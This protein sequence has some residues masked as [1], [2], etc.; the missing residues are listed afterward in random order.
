MIR[1]EGVQVQGGLSIGPIHFLHRLG[2]ASSARSLLSPSEELLRFEAARDRAAVELRRLSARIAAHLGD[3][4]AAIF[5]FQSMMLEDED[6]LR[7]IYDCI[8][9]SS[10]AESAIE[11]A[12]REAIRFFASLDSSYLR[13]RAA[14][15]RDVTRRLTGILSQQADPGKLRQ[16]PA[17]LVAED[18]TPSETALLDSG[19]LLGLVSR[20]GS[21]DSHVAILAKAI[22]VPTLTGVAVDPH[23]EG[24][25]AILDGDHGALIVDPDEETMQA[26]RPHLPADYRPI[27]PEM[28][29]PHRVRSDR[30][31]RLSAMID[32]AWEAADAYA[33]GAGAISPYGTSVLHGSR[34]A[35]P[36]EEEQFVEYRRTVE[37]MH[38][39]PVL[40]RSLDVGVLGRG[41]ALGAFAPAGDLAPLKAQ[42]R[43]VLRAADG[44]SGGLLL[45]GV[46]SKADIHRARQL[47]RQ[48]QR[49][50]DAEGKTY[51][52]V[53]VGTEIDSP[54]SVFLTDVLASES[55]LLLLDGHSLMHSTIA[56]PSDDALPSYRVLTMMLQHA[57]TIGH[58]RGCSVIFS[59][60]L[61]AFPQAVQPLLNLGV[62]ELSVPL[63]S[64]S[65][66]FRLCQAPAEPAL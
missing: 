26:A 52:K 14:D 59:G 64:L 43:A 21:V 8:N 54:A 32:S 9:D 6:I 45:S 60:D 3:D 53:S 5:L 46:R 2:S 31:V 40:F 49:E 36:S 56:G 33:A 30:T 22:G 42:F 16:T 1:V 15:A 44:F 58:Q 29:V 41:G 23:W 28:T 50:L 24:R 4:N 18:L 10:T 37:A 66:L 25:T 34:A 48:C 61:E 57:V 55:D 38:G 12:E 63:R 35:P 27:A 39:R 13:S 51:R 11:Q 20:D 65:A 47:L 7:F 62:D 19:L 17:I